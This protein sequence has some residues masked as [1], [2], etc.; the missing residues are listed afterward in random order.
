[1]R[2]RYYEC[3]LNGML[4]DPAIIS[5]TSS[6]EQIRPTVTEA[7]MNVVIYP[8]AG[9]LCKHCNFCFGGARWKPSSICTS[10][11]NVT[12]CHAGHAHWLPMKGNQSRIKNLT[13]GQYRGRLTPA[14]ESLQVKLIGLFLQDI[15]M[16]I[17]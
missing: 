5:A 4:K 1:M 13:L 8:R 2:F 9:V 6:P 16:G 15:L 14:H 10:V 11:G 12:T 17:A 3:S 7:G